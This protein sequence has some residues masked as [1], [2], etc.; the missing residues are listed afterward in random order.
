MRHSYSWSTIKRHF[1]TVA[2]A[3]DEGLA[4]AACPSAPN[5]PPGPAERRKRVRCGSSGGLGRHRR[6][7]RSRREPSG[8]PDCRPAAVGRSRPDRRRDHRVL[9]SQGRRLLATAKEGGRPS[10]S[11]VPGSGGRS[12]L[13]GQE[14][15]APPGHAGAG[16]HRLDQGEPEPITWSRRADGAR[17]EGAT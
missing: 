9:D 3:T 10:R 12:G 13:T 16:A 1:G 14:R 8:E 11:A 17:P 2:R 5:C 7:C 15:T 6:L 4:D